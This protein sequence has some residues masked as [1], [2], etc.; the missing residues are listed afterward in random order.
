MACVLILVC[1][2]CNEYWLL[3]S[4]VLNIHFPACLFV[5]RSPNPAGPLSGTLQSN[6]YWLSRSKARERC[7]SI[8][9]KVANSSGPLS[10]WPALT[11]AFKLFACFALV[12]KNP[13]KVQKWNQVHESINRIAITLKYWKS[14]TRYFRKMGFN[15]FKKSFL[16][17]SDKCF[18]QSREIV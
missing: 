15:N 7:L 2:E 18:L 8:C 13:N 14:L 10:S 4:K 6:E 17:T 1:T 3:R 5:E 12:Q 11:R 9:E 16:K